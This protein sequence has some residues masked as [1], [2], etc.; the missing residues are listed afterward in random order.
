VTTRFLLAADVRGYLPLMLTTAATVYFFANTLLI[1]GVISLLEERSLFQI[2]RQCHLWTFPYF[3]A[4]GAIAGLISTASRS[5]GWQ[6]PL[7]SL[8]LMY[9]VYKFYQLYVQH[10]SHPV[11]T[12]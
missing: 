8:P 5:V 3:L 6:L 11:E 4:G 12:S 10:L 7:L 9:F 1:S 2:W